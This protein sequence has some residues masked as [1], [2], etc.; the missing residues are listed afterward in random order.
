MTNNKQWFDIDKQG[1]A[2]ILKR[3]G[4][5]FA[6]FELIQNAWDESGV[7]CV[8]VNLTPADKAK[9]F[10]LLTVRDDAPEGF[11]DLRHAYTLFAESAK[12]S[13]AEQRGR[14]NLGEKL[15]LSLCE[16]A[17]ITT[18]KG[19]VRFDKDGRNETTMNR[20]EHGTQFTA[21]IQMT[22]AEI[23]QVTT[24]VQR[25][26]PPFDIKTTFNGVRIENREITE[27]VSAKL[28]TELS[29]DEGRL[30]RTDRKAPI[31]CY[32]VNDG[33][34]AFIYEMGIPVVEH[35]CAF[36]CDV[37]QKVPL[38]M[39]RE[40][41]TPEFLRKLRAAIFNVTHASLTIEDMN[42]EWVQT[43][44]ESKD[45]LP[46][47]VEDFMTKRFGELRATYDPSDPE[48]NNKAV[49]KGYTIVKGGMLSGAAWKNVKTFETIAPAGQLFPT[50]S[51]NYVMTEPADETDAMRTVRAYA[52]Q[53][54]EL[55]LDCTIT[56]HFGAQ[57]SNEL[58][59]WSHRMLSFNVTNL[60]AHWF[61][62]AN[63]RLAIDDLI[64]H[65]FGHHY[66]GNHLSSDYNDALSRLAAKAM[67]LGR[68][69]K[70][71]A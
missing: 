47:A 14:F 40:N 7:S 30:R 19:T 1:L 4:V 65:E 61:N 3:K 41:V 63:N 39:D 2:K 20:R 59:S 13:N 38:T 9:G 60:G 25:L 6:V 33:E 37:Q 23:A 44:I 29:D 11:S 16:W 66:C 45:V 68:A 46:E 17:E 57:P 49:S 36:H 52:Q 27:I 10:A 18:T 54:A 8:E 28:P 42:H 71:P 35:D 26:I 48:A 32:A 22:N 70:L 51:D 24:A 21:K 62:L 67:A 55:L 64:I 53:L 50:H 58:A 56:V 12:K 15:V 5:E 43:A 34:T 69:G 31:H